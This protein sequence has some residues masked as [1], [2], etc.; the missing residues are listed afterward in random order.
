MRYSNTPFTLSLV[1]TVNPPSD[2]TVVKMGRK[3]GNPAE[4]PVGDEKLRLTPRRSDI[5]VPYMSAARP[6]VIDR[7]IVILSN[8]R[9]SS[10]ARE[11]FKVDYSISLQKANAVAWH[12]R[13]IYCCP[14]S[15]LAAR[16][17]SALSSSFLTMG[18]SNL[19]EELEMLT[20]VS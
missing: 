5:A 8:E 16:E 20:E 17:I 10:G 7:L 11:E 9:G 18:Q 15:L 4:K 3:I 2:A 13:D 12:Y 6:V 1:K 19:S 14:S